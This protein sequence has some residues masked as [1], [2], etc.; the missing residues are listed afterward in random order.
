MN[1]HVGK[2]GLVPQSSWI[3]LSRG[4]ACLLRPGHPSFRKYAG[5]CRMGIV[6][7]P[8]KSRPPAELCEVG[9]PSFPPGPNHSYSIP[10]VSDR[11]PLSPTL[12]AFLDQSV[13]VCLQVEVRAHWILVDCFRT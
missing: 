2:K 11:W 6:S 7:P 1:C 10:K 5:P 4:S 9:L 3:E 12:R 8:R 13:E